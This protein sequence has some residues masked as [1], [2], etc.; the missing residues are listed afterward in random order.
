VVD[1]GMFRWTMGPLGRPL[2]AEC[3]KFLNV[4]CFLKS[5]TGLFRRG[6]LRFQVTNKGKDTGATVWLLTF[7]FSLLLL[8]VTAVGYGIL[9]FLNASTGLERLGLGVA[10]FFAGLFCLV[11]AVSA[12]FAFERMAAHADYTF[13]DHLDA[14]AMLG[15]TPREVVVVRANEFEVR[16]VVPEGAPAPSP[17]Q[18]VVLAVALEDARPPLHLAGTIRALEATAVGTSVQL[19]LDPLQNDARDRLFD[20]LCEHAIPGMIDPLVSAWSGRRGQ[21]RPTQTGSYYL[22]LQPKVL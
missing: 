8:N 5:L 11:G 7:Q 15:G 6:R 18:Q 13:P 10:G 14:T 22:P 16:F 1:L 20:R 21:P 4:Y 3:Y 2:L 12:I 9:R 17:G 19:E